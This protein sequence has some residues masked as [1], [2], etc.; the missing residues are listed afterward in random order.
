[1]EQITTALQSHFQP[2]ALVIPKRFN[3]HRHNQ[4]LNESIA[5]Y[6]AELRRV[7]THCE[8]R[9]YLNDALL[10]QLL[11]GLQNQNIQNKLLSED[12]L[13]LMK[14]LEITQGMEAAEANMKKL[15]SSE[16]TQVTVMQ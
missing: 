15:R 5:E 16:L 13:I 9:D 12:H 3:F 14:I 1:M 10:D 4:L 11:C 2:K 6:M 7:A 8:F